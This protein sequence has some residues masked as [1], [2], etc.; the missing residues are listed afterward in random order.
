MKGD[1]QFLCQQC[2]DPRRPL[3]TRQVALVAGNQDGRPSL[4][5]GMGEEVVKKPE[6]GREGGRKGGREAGGEEGWV[7]ENGWLIV[8]TSVSVDSHSI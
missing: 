6:E 7:N 3:G 4:H 5:R 2:T 1:V 8:K